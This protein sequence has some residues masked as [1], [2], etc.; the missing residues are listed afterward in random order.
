MLRNASPFHSG[1]EARSILAAAL[2][3]SSSSGALAQD[4]GNV[5][6]G[7]ESSD[8][9]ELIPATSAGLPPILSGQEPGAR[10]RGA[11]SEPAAAVDSAREWFTASPWWT[12]QRAT[13]DWDGAR[14]AL[15]D[16]GIAF[17]GSLISEWSD[18]FRG[19]IDQKSAFRFLLDLNLSLD[20]SKL[21]GIEGGSVFLD[22]QTAD[23]GSGAQ[24]YGEFQTYSNI[25][26]DGSITQLSQAYYEQ[27]LFDRALRVKVGKVD[28]NTEFAYIASAGGFINAS[29]GFTPTIFALPTY[30]NASTSVNLFVYPS[31][32]TYLGAGVYDGA[33]AVDGVPTGSRGPSTFFSDDESDDWFFI[34]EAGVT[35]E[36]F[37]SM[38][39]ARAAVGGWWHTGDFTA[40]SGGNE[41][42]AG[43]FYA[44]A[45]ARVWGPQAEESDAACPCCD[46]L[47]VF[48]QYGWAQDAVSVATQQIGGG[49]T[50]V[51]TFASRENDS[52]GL[53][54]SY[55]DFTNDASGLYG[56]SET[57]F[58]LFYD[59]ALTPSVHLKPDLQY[60]VNPGLD[61]STDDALVGTLRLTIV[62]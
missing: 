22:F 39:D 62:F 17:A 26:I 6:L 54:I 12:W 59:I 30:P 46:G 40:F 60:F 38:N 35:L 3:L 42:G 34:A 48:A 33:T 10:E 37:G 32:H 56:A 31:E 51:G 45:E 53:Y 29:S 1:S 20:L 18:V 41:D 23:A 27:W 49:V 21:A 13:G 57:S 55:V 14:N 5:V 8:V 61:A 52:T 44:L 28:A 9:A 4:A 7:G 19:G 15:D 11:T 58:E 2:V 36:S 25:A 24:F 16:A 47:F 50:L 43:G